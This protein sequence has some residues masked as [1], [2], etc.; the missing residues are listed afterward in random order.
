MAFLP[1]ALPLIAAGGSLIQGA[2][3]L[4][5]GLK[6]KKRAYAAGREEI[7]ASNAEQLEIRKDA[8]RKIGSQIAAQW[9]NGLEGGSG[10]SLAALR[11]SQLEA[12]LDVMEAR[13]Q[14][15]SRNAALRAQGKAAE[16]E[17]YF[18][19]AGSLLGAASGYNSMKTDWAQARS[20]TSAGGGY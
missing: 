4:M 3:G 12:A 16:R 17:G 18:S 19:A 13:R 8:R 5:A 9:G 20:G 10:T 7:R 15:T 14:G 2:G 6:N 11:E 1:A